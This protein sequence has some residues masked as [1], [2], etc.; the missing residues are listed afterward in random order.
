V[1]CRPV[2]RAKW[3]KKVI[4]AVPNAPV[5]P[6]A[7]PVRVLMVLAK[8]VMRVN[9]VHPMTLL[10]IRA[11]YAKV[12]LIKTKEVKRLVCHAYLARMKTIL[13]QPIVNSA[14]LDNTKMYLA[15]TLV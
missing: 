1:D 8:H 10:L 14:A 13:V 15:T 3:V 7:K 11:H 9:H 6:L 12:A 5:V 2:I 4:R